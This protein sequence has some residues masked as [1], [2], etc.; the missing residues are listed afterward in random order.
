MPSTPLE[1]LIFGCRQ[2]KKMLTSYAM[3]LLDINRNL[4]LFAQAQ[5]GVSISYPSIALHAM[6][7]REAASLPDGAASVV[8]LQINIHD[9]RTTNSDDE[10]HTLDLSIHATEIAVGSVQSQEG[11]QVDLPHPVKAL[12]EALSACADLHPDPDED[13]SAEE[14]EPEPGT[15][16][17]ITAENMNDFMDADGNFVA[18]S[19]LGPGAGTV[20][21]R[22]DDHVEDGI[23]G[24]DEDESKWQRTA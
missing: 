2:G 16:G 12:F 14:G 13:E 8:F 24:H 23:N 6:G 3:S 18:P 7:M 5:K 4:I 9:H 19:A 20:R 17:W 21:G 22:D 15:G 10:I 1:M 11:D